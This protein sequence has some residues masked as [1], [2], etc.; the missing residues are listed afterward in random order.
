[1]TKREYIEILE[2]KGL[3]EAGIEVGVI[4]PLLQRD[5]DMYNYYLLHVSKG[6]MNAYSL[7]AEKFHMV[8]K[9]AREIIA[10]MQK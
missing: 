3:F 4:K 9:R 8:E 10:N 6:K 1:M 7:C 5:I 2:E